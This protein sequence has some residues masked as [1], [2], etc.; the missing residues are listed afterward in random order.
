MNMDTAKPLVLY[1]G[2]LKQ[3]GHYMFYDDGTEVPYPTSITLTPWKDTID[4][5]IQPGQTLWRE[6]WVARGNWKHGEAVIHHKDGWTAL[7]FWDSTI[8]TRPGCSSTYL[9]K[10]TFDF[11]GMVA[12]AKERFAE[13][14][15]KMQFE[16][17]EIH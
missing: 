5:Q 12:L 11:E 7:S 10:G 16:V 9:A 4:G 17:V 6:H 3:S 1:F 15:N 13:R 2:P 8:D 14:W